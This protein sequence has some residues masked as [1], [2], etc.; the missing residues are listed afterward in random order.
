M[1]VENVQHIET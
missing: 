1:G